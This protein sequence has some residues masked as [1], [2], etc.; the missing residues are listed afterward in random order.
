MFT[1]VNRHGLVSSFRMTLLR[2]YIVM[3]G[4]FLLPGCQNAE[5][6]GKPPGPPDPFPRPPAPEYT[7]VDDH[8]VV[9]VRVPGAPHTARQHLERIVQDIAADH[10]RHGRTLVVFLNPQQETPPATMALERL[11]MSAFA[12]GTPLPGGK[13]IVQRGTF[14]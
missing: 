11:V 9:L 1:E 4:L 13:A 14:N 10:E 6:P 2:S 7:I 5:S 8:Y 3:L 12:L